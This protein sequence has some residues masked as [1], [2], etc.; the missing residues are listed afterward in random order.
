MRWE[1]NLDT[2]LAGVLAAN[3]SSFELPRSYRQASLLV[4]RHPFFFERNQHNAALSGRSLAFCNRMSGF[5][6]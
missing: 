2:S 3:E 6:A 1:P 5:V 4:S